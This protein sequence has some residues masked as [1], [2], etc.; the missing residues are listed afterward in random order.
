ML[1]PCRAAEDKPLRF[2]FLGDLHY[3]QPQYAAQ[4]L[5]EAIA[6]EVK[7][8][9]PPVDFV[10]HTGD[11][12]HG[13]VAGKHV[14]EALAEARREWEF[15]S[16]HVTTQ[17]G[18]PFFMA[19]GNHDWY[20]D[21]FRGGKKNVVEVYIPFMGRQLGR[22]LHEPFFSFDRGNSHFVFLNHY[23]FDAAWDREQE[24]WLRRD[25]SA[26]ENNPAV[27]HIFIFGHPQLW[28]VAVLSFDEHRRYRP[29]LAK[30]RID[31]YF[32][33]HVHRNTVSVWDFGERKMAQIVGVPSLGG[34]LM[35]IEES[36]LILNP[37]P[38]K[39]AYYRGFY[40]GGSYYL[41]SI[42]GARV[43]V[44]LRVLGKGAAWEFYWDRPSEIVDVKAPAPEP[45][46]ILKASDLPNVVEAKLYLAHLARPDPAA[47]VLLNGQQIGVLREKYEPFWRPQPFDVPASLVKLKNELVV[48]NP[49]RES[50]AFK[51]C[52]LWVKLA[53][54]R[55]VKT[56]VSPHV[57]CSSPELPKELTPRVPSEITQAVATGS[58][59]T[60]RLDFRS[61][62]VS[63]R[64]SGPAGDVR[65]SLPARSRQYVVRSKGADRPEWN[66][67]LVVLDRS[68]Y[69]EYEFPVL[70]PC[71]VTV[72]IH[73]QCELLM[74]ASGKK[75]LEHTEQREPGKRAAAWPM[76]W[77]E[78]KLSRE[79]TADGTLRL[80][81][82]DPTKDDGWGPNYD[83]IEVIFYYGSDGPSVRP[84]VAELEKQIAGFRARLARLAIGGDAVEYTTDRIQK[85]AG[86]AGE[87][88]EK[89][90]ATQ[91]EWLA[92]HT[93][94]GQ[95]RR[96][97]A[98]IE[99]QIGTYE[100]LTKSGVVGKTLPFGVGVVDNMTKVRRGMPLPTT[101]GR[102]AALSACR[103]EHEGFQ[104]VV[105]PFQDRLDQARLSVGPL[106]SDT[107]GVIPASQV[108][109][110][111]V[112][113]MGLPFG[114]PAT[115]V[116]EWWPDPLLPGE[117]ID[118]K[119]RDVQAFWVDVHVPPDA[120]PGDYRGHVAV[121]ADGAPEV[122]IPIRLHVYNFAL[123][124]KPLLRTH[125]KAYTD[126]AKALVAAHRLSPGFVLY[127]KM[128][129]GMLPFEQIKSLL[130]KGL[131][132]VVSEGWNT[133]MIEMPFW[134]GMHRPSA[135]PG[136]D[137]AS[138]PKAYT[139]E[140]KA[141]IAEYYGQ[142][143]THLDQRGL[144]EEGYIYLWDEP[145]PRH[146]ASIR[147]LA[148]VVHVAAPK[149]RR[150]VTT[151]PSDELAG[152]VDIWVPLVPWFTEK[153][154]AI[155]DKHRAAGEQV[156]CY[157]CGD[158]GGRYASLTPLNLPLIDARLLFW[159]I[160][161]IKA[162]GFLY[163][164]TEFAYGD[165][166][167]DPATSRCLFSKPNRFSPGDG[168]L[169][170]HPPGRTV[171]SIRLEAIRDGVE[172]WEYLAILNDRVQRA[173]HRQLSPATK[174]A[175]EAATRLARATQTVSKSLTEYTRDPRVLRAAREQI[176]QAIEAMRALR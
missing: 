165:F 126:E 147:D 127:P 49:R 175:L 157:V 148:E 5:V 141:Y 120:A 51:S 160:W 123:P 30:H 35:P 41:V 33:G 42:E 1:S 16:R 162:D 171:G 48:K 102:Q 116:A 172:D 9:K 121:T 64:D 22:K 88:A 78:L 169:I 134:R 21:T 100:T 10:C 118:S 119:G 107:G 144:T 113:H 2:V 170:Y 151:A 63:S 70:A 154:L 14:A 82:E 94:M 167:Y 37:P 53:D 106:R 111:V 11:F 108:N 32:C 112:A 143:Q 149:L 59:M 153:H 60:L 164:M 132:R 103:N 4:R 140:Q 98:A 80:R 45:K 146:Y 168:T 124:R 62:G 46:T 128:P 104:V 131:D 39:R 65:L 38:S 43:T 52:H 24:V 109:H 155:A 86:R 114:V 142:Y 66:P 15:A 129:R 150:L 92:L 159:Q 23:G 145:S 67:N 139:E 3:H 6:R 44:Q 152:A 75:V 77:H 17:F 87:I 76:R 8:L 73:N 47:P 34:D 69:V 136:G 27:K 115:D 85:F 135:A 56:P 156:W 161:R 130:T 99:T 97:G 163:W 138:Q 20:G 57:V 93:R 95:V 58:D 83:R 133:F 50:F 137:N 79:F 13:Q 36:E 122:T 29:V 158:P 28:N 110:F 71:P 166:S 19:L 18:L 31:A 7:T 12:I 68:G 72:R 105:C 125:V 55:T 74:S 26:A 173:F 176:A 89:P 81:L 101:V 54:G 91:R 84:G 174:P 96:E 90:A 40:R 61:A 25:L 117:P